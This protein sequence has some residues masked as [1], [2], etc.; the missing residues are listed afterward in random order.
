MTSKKLM[1]IHYCLAIAAIVCSLVSLYGL[2]ELGSPRWT[3]SVNMLAL[4]LILLAVQ[5]R[6]RAAG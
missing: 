1:W 6:R 3:T 4:V 5:A 2:V